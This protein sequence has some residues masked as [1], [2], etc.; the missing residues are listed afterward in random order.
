[1]KNVP[2]NL[3][4]YF[5]YDA[6]IEFLK[7]GKL[8]LSSVEKF[9]DPFEFLVRNDYP[10]FFLSLRESTSND[11]LEK[12]IQKLYEE[13]LFVCRNI[14]RNKA[15]GYINFMKTFRMCCFSE[16]SNNLLMWAH[17]AEDFRGMVISFNT[18]LEYWGNDFHQVCYTDNRI[19]YNDFDKERLAAKEVERTLLKNKASV[20]SYE[21]EWRYIKSRNHCDK[22]K[23]GYY[24]RIPSKYIQR[25]IVGCK[26]DISHYSKIRN[27]I[28]DNYSKS[29][30]FKIVPSSYGFSLDE[31][32]IT[33]KEYWF[34]R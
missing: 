23:D 12:K 6:G 10:E 4:R 29:K 7:T 9:N 34:S 26:M 21:K 11:E 3:Y 16:E 2:E 25:I 14:V 20:W 31:K 32:D 19:D 33:E 8:R 30:I 22:D 28:K 17:Y 18:S 1:M 5:R 13:E 15:K 24:M 27:I